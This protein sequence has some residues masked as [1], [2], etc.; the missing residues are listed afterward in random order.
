MADT[1]PL[2][3]ATLTNGAA[4]CVTVSTRFGPQS[5]VWT[6]PLSRG[7]TAVLAINGADASHD[8]ELDF[9]DVLAPAAGLPRPQG[10]RSQL[11]QPGW[12]VRDLWAAEH[13]RDL[14]V[15]STLRRTL[16]P[17]DCVML[18]LAPTL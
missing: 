16:A 15:H 2:E 11:A 5:T 18:V 14:G 6:K 9:A 17:H 10:N 12:H 7:R 8:V 1:L 13:A 4:G 3:A